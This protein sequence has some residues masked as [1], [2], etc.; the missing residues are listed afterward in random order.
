MKLV[1]ESLEDVGFQPAEDESRDETNFSQEQKDTI[2]KFVQDYEGDFED[3]DIHNLAGELGLD[4]PEVEEFIYNMARKTPGPVE[5]NSDK[6]GFHTNIE[7]D[8]KQNKEFRKVLYTGENLQLVIMT[9]KP[10][11]DI[12]METH[13]TI[14]QFIRIDD[15]S[16]KCVINGNEYPLKNGDAII[17][18]AGC[19]HNIIAGPKSPLKLYT[20]YSPPH[21]KDGIEFKTKEEAENSKEEFDGVTTE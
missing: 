5:N 7:E 6:K 1:K 9:L 8:T 16:G 12:G 15:G 10:G 3:E 14:D 4:K 2:E 13:E 17:V 18:P 20:V 19:E 11:E 21:H